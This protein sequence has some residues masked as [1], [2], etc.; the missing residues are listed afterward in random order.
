MHKIELYDSSVHCSPSSAH[1]IVERKNYILQD[2]KPR[3]AKHGS[4]IKCCDI[5]DMWLLHSFEHA[6]C[7][8]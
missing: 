5:P 2:M 7:V 4:N 8:L 6:F 3:K 1:F